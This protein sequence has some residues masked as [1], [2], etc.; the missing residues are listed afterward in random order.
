MNQTRDYITRK[1]NN[2]VAPVT[3]ATASEVEDP[4]EDPSLL[5]LK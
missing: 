4:R 1:A 3:A 5:Q 2:V